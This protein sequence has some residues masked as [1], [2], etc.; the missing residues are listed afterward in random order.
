MKQTQARSSTAT[1]QLLGTHCPIRWSLA[2]PAPREILVLPVPLVL[3]AHRAQM[4]AL[5]PPELLVP[6][7]LP[8]LLVLPA[9]L[10]L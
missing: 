1:V 8:V 7:A 4:V 9:R 10:Q 6:R 3:L 5:E 2:P